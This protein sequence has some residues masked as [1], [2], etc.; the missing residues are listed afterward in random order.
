MCCGLLRP[1][2]RCT[3]LGAV[4]ILCLR[5]AVAALLSVS[6]L[7]SS[8]WAQQPSSRPPSNLQLNIYSYGQGAPY[9]TPYGSPQ[10]YNGVNNLPDTDSSDSAEQSTPVRT[11]SWTPCVR[12]AAT[13]P[14]SPRLLTADLV[15]AQ[16]RRKSARAPRPQRRPQWTPCEPRLPAVIAISSSTV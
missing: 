6:A 15:V 3:T 5:V 11:L 8:S 10:P 12:R 9:G 14:D 2:L 7:P 1:R 13:D 16:Y 4:M